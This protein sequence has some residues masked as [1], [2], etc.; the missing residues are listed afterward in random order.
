MTKEAERLIEVC[1]HRFEGGDKTA[2]LDAIDFCARS[3]TVMPVWLAEA[4]CAAY[5]EW[6]T[7]K[8]RSLDQAFGVERKGRRIPDLQEREA[9]KASVVIEV[10]KLRQ[11][12]V[13]TDEMLFD[14]VEKLNIPAGQARDIY[15]KDNPWRKFNDAIGRMLK[16]DGLKD[17]GD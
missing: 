8:V 2:L 17:G 15:Y 3:A 10:D 12:K 16:P 1:Q 11:E 4:Y 13:P 14:R 7:Y 5:T 6:A 9:L